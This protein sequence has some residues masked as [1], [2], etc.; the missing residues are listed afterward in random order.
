MVRGILVAVVA[1]LGPASC[2]KTD[3]GRP[4]TGGPLV[5]V[6]APDAGGGPD[7]APAAPA[8][9]GFCIENWRVA[10]PP[11][12]RVLDVAWVGSQAVLL[13]EQDGTLLAVVVGGGGQSLAAA[14]Q[15][16]V[17]EFV[18]G[19][20]PWG[21]LVRGPE[22]T[23]ALYGWIRPRTAAQLFGRAVRPGGDLAPP[24]DAQASLKRFFAVRP[25]PDWELTGDPTVPESRVW[26]TPFEGQFVV[27]IDLW[28]RD[29]LEAGRMQP[30]KKHLFGLFGSSGRRA[31]GFDLKPSRGLPP[32]VV[33]NQL[34]VAVDAAD[35]KYE[36]LDARGRRA[37]GPL[38]EALNADPSRVPFA[39]V[40]TTAGGCLGL[41]A[42]AGQPAAGLPDLQTIAADGT[43]GEWA[44]PPDLGA[45]STFEATAGGLLWARAAD[46][47]V[48][49][50]GPDGVA[51][52]R[53]TLPEGAVLRRYASPDVLAAL[54][55]A[56]G[57]VTHVVSCTPGGA[58]AE[59][60]RAVALEGTVAEARQAVAGTWNEMALA[61]L[62]AIE[63]VASGTDRSSEER[64]ERLASFADVRL[65][66]SRARALDPDLLV[67]ALTAARAEILAGD[68]DAARREFAAIDAAEPSR[69]DRLRLL[70]CRD[71]RLRALRWH[72]DIGAAIGCP[73]TP[74]PWLALP[75]PLPGA[76]VPDAGALAPL[77]LPPAPAPAPAPAPVPVPDAGPPRPAP[78]EPFGELP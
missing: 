36:L 39:S 71:A 51:A 15:D 42:A 10:V 4:D 28:Q 62:D 24:A 14:L 48:W 69:R 57:R 55:D 59:T 25:R 2:R 46:G 20:A 8:G 47:A 45:G 30:V 70:A 44:L 74:P 54:A 3:A 31:G 21:V 29:R 40:C 18:D 41:L 26:T 19:R 66:A 12:A 68:A 52:H 33:G 7:T 76:V 75:L 43:R 61:A 58:R 11:A 78:V 23:L 13:L 65:M 72:P 73:E 64:V 60:A 50:A 5:V 37:A 49:A 22:R 35:R 77:A 63:E 27:L 16:F 17:P 67:A 53:T 34:V 56:A 9:R 38:L 6:Q 32:A 1:L